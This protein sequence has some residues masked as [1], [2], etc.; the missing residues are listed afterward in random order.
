MIG[1]GLSYC[2]L[3]TYLD[4]NAPALSVNGQA[5]IP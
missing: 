2:Y 5:D 4:D 3:L 1:D